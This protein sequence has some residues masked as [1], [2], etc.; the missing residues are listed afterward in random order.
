[1]LLCRVYTAL[2]EYSIY[3]QYS[4]SFKDILFSYSRV[5]TASRLLHLATIESKQLQGY[6][7]YLQPQEYSI[8]Q[9]YCRVNTGPGIFYNATVESIQL[10]EY[11]IYL[12]QSLYI[13]RK[14]YLRQNSLCSRNI[15][16]V[17]SRVWTAQVIFFLATVSIYSSRNILFIL[18]R[19][20]KCELTIVTKCT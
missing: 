12:Q 19:F 17:Y 2:Q 15:L 14:I 1:M 5:Q 10:H 13:F 9:Q 6:Y 20:K 16:F 18:C 11:S 3:L 8:L 7:V 4:F